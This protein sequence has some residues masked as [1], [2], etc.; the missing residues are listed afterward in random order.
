MTTIT[1]VSLFKLFLPVIVVPVLRS[2]RLRYHRVGSVPCLQLAAF[3]NYG[4]QM[5]L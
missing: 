4:R 5:P 3:L 2:A 1:A